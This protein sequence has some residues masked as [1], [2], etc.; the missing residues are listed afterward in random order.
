MR[1]K[2]LFIALASSVGLLFASAGFAASSGS[3][4]EP[5]ADMAMMNHN[6]ASGMNWFG[7]EPYTGK[8]ALKATAALVRAG[9]GVDNFSFATALVAMLGQDTVNAE[10]AKLTKQYGK[11]DVTGFIN[12]MTY[13]VN[14]ALRLA[15]ASGI[16]L[17]QPPADLKGPAL[18]KALVKA[19]VGSDGTFWAGRM[20]D[21]AISHNLHNAVMADIEANVSHFAD[22]STHRVLNQAM[23]DVAQALG[24]KDVKLA[25]FH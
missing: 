21:V 19:G 6:I 7:G 14:S 1:K 17:P 2:A 23:Y 20:F 13:A 25:S 8:P 18:A 11:K 5:S 16:A 3:T 22:W 12:G 4:A 10:V 15:A 9:G 24:M